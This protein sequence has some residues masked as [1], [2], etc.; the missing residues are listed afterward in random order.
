MIGRLVTGQSEQPS[1]RSGSV[2]AVARRQGRTGIRVALQLRVRPVGGE[3][4]TRRRR[5]A[6]TVHRVRC[7]LGEQAVTGARA[8]QQRISNWK[9]GAPDTLDIILLAEQC[10]EEIAARRAE[11]ECAGRVEHQMDEIR[12]VINGADCDSRRAVEVAIVDC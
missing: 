2:V 9:N 12:D 8:V 5:R 1:H 7:T 11:L 10:R 3:H 6:R 4:A